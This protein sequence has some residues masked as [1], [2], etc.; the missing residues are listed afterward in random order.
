M[1]SDFKDEFQKKHFGFAD[2]VPNSFY[3]SQVSGSILK[4][5]S[6]RPS[7]GAKW[8]QPPPTSE[9]WPRPLLLTIHIA[10]VQLNYYFFNQ[11]LNVFN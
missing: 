5:I 3:Q 9:A 11:C 2:C 10:N 8:G 4:S 7:A 1:T 6:A